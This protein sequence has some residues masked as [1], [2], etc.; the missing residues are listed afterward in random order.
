VY[1]GGNSTPFTTGVTLTTDYNSTVGLND[2]SIGATGA[3]YTAG[4]DYDVVVTAG[5]VGGVS[6]IGNVVGHF[7][8]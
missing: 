8:L 2:V 1:Q 7:T 5:T 4:H 3:N 6:Q